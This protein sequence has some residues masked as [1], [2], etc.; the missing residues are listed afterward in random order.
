MLSASQKSRLSVALCVAGVAAV[1]YIFATA[2]FSWN[3]IPKYILAPQIIAG[4][5]VTLVLT[6]L[7]MAIGIAIG[8]VFAMMRVSSLLMPQVVAAGYIWLFRGIPLLVQII[9]WFNLALFMPRIGFGDYS[10]STNQVMG[11]F[12][13]ALIALSLNEG[14][15]MAEIVRGGILAIDRGQVEAARA[16]GLS[17]A[18]TFRRIVL[19][20]ALRMVIP[21]TGNQLIGMLKAT[22]LVSVIGVHDLLTQAQFIYTA[23]YLIMELL[24]VAAIWYLALTALASL[25]QHFLEKWASHR[26]SDPREEVGRPQVSSGSEQLV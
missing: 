25:L 6:I 24:I 1:L 2:S 21:A 10:V 13:A 3:E 22:S 26:P 17:R 18:R 5:R 20:Q 7:S 14:A 19:P 11:S 15:Y 8:V 12:T 23:N 4:A 16:L 9:F